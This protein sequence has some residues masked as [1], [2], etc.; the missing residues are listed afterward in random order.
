MP[1]VL[2]MRSR[3]Y[4]ELLNP[5]YGYKIARVDR[6]TPWGNFAYRVQRHTEEEYTR[7]VQAYRASLGDSH[8]LIEVARNRTMAQGGLSDAEFLACWCA[9]MPCHGDVWAEVLDKEKETS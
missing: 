6:T 1:I 2:N 3:E 7:A 4:K 8:Y 9:P 5:K